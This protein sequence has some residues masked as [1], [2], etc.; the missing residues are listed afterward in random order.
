MQTSA[1]VIDSLEFARSR[2]A[3]R[4]TLGLASLQRLAE[5]LSDGEGELVFE[6]RGEIDARLRPRLRIIV[7][8]DINLRCQ[9]CLGGMRHHLAVD[10]SLLVLKPGDQQEQV[11]IDD[12][13]G[14]PASACTEIS[15]LIEDEVLLALPY[16]P[17][18]DEGTCASVAGAD[19]SRVDSPFAALARLKKH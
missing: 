16:A 3:L 11:D 13:D 10:S 17:R 18:H 7:E 4:G 9:R 8:G 19:A 2:K 14:V 6:V 12:L 1:T 15:E 5:S